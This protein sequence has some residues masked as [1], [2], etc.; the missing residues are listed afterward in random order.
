[1]GTIGP[2]RNCDL[3]LV[4]AEV[5]EERLLEASRDVADNVANY[6][7]GTFPD[8]PVVLQYSDGQL[9]EA[10]KGKERGDRQGKEILDQLQYF[11]AWRTAVWRCEQRV[12]GNLNLLL[13]CAVRLEPVDEAR[14]L[15]VVEYLK[16]TYELDTSWPIRKEFRNLW[17]RDQYAEKYAERRDILP[18]WLRTMEEPPAGHGT[19]GNPDEDYQAKMENYDDGNY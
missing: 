18:L 17:V 19:R 6:G 16:L 10:W 4:G 1:M 15:K 2:R 12:I 14:A 8:R 7:P 3:S 5:T 9:H 13:A 11:S